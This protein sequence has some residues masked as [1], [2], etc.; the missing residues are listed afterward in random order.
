MLE[1]L[2]FLSL[3][4]FEF[5]DLNVNL[6]FFW[7]NSLKLFQYF[8]SLIVSTQDYQSDCFIE[9]VVNICWH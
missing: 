9:L 6:R 1:S 2:L 8:K 4:L 7:A 5:S 3:F